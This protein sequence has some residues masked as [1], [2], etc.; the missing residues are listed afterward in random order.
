MDK[1]EF[2]E[3]QKNFAKETQKRK[4]TKALNYI[5]MF[6]SVLGVSVLTYYFAKSIFSN[7][8][9]EIEKIKKENIE[10]TYRIKELQTRLKNAD[11]IITFKTPD[12]ERLIALENKIETLNNI[13]IE[14]PEKSLTIPFMRKD[15]QN[16]KK[17]N[18]LE[19][20]HIKEKVDTVIDLN[21]WILGLIFSLL[22]TIVISNL[23]KVKSNNGEQ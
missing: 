6:L 21:K 16:I 10:L 22:I 8:N 5:T 14:N 19:I 13:I 11:T 18:D 1:Q 15:I 7:N 9:S 4:F 20:E 2:D 12:E 17:D 3:L 23:S